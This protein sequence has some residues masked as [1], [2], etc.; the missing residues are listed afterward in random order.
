[1][2]M[3][4][5]LVGFAAGVFAAVTVFLLGYGWLWVLLAYSG[6]GALSILLAAII[7]LVRQDWSV[8]RSVS[9][10]VDTERKLIFD[11]R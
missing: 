9:N 11:F 8:E 3:F 5:V 7:I 2:V 6:A 1:M 10:S 4:L